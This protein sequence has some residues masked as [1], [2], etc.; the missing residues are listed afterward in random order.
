MVLEP[1]VFI[2]WRWLLLGDFPLLLLVEYALGH[3]CVKCTFVLLLLIQLS[4]ALGCTIRV[5]ALAC[6]R[7]VAIGQ[8]MV[9]YPCELAH[10]AL[11]LAVLQADLRL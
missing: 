5:L 7:L 3:I 10:S 2:Q 6:D 9:L 1:K 4:V 11:V 8:Q